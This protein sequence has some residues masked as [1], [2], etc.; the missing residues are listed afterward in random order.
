MR[1]RKNTWIT[2]RLE[3]PPLHTKTKDMIETTKLNATFAQVFSNCLKRSK[4]FQA[5]ILEKIV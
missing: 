1:K 4:L 5:S 2:S 3:W